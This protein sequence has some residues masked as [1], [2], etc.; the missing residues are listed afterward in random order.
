M[1]LDFT[2]G[3]LEVRSPDAPVLIDQEGGL[4]RRVPDAPPSRSANWRLPIAGSRPMSR[5]GA[6]T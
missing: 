4:V 2:L 5:H 6:A 3:S 1:A